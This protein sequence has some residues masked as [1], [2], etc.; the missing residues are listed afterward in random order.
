MEIND[1]IED[2]MKNEMERNKM[3]KDSIKC[4]IFKNIEYIRKDFPKGNVELIQNSL[5][6]I[7][8]IFKKIKNI[9]QEIIPMTSTVLFSLL[10]KTSEMLEQNASI[11]PHYKITIETLNTITIIINT[12]F[13]DLKLKQY[14]H[15]DNKSKTFIKNVYINLK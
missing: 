8:M 5:M 12:V 14:N 11:I 13:N 2:K 9:V 15:S 6:L 10:A 1:E 4:F 3:L 7:Q